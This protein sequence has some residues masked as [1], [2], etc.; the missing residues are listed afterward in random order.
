MRWQNIFSVLCEKKPQ[1]SNVCPIWSIPNCQVTS[2]IL[3]MNCNIFKDYKNG[4]IGG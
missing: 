2:T 1:S 4:H 3:S